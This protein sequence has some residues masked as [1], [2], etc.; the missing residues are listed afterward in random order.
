[1]KLKNTKKNSGFTLVELLVVIAIIAGLAAISSPIIIR[2]IA[3]SRA[4]QA[5]NNGKDIYIGLRDYAFSRGGKTPLAA[6]S[7][8]SLNV[9][10]TTGVLVDDKPFFVSG[11]PITDTPPNGDKVLDAGQ[12]IYS[13]FSDGAEAPNITNGSANNPVLATPI[14]GSG[15]G[16][17]DATFFSAAFGGQGVVIFADGAGVVFNLAG[18]AG[19]GTTATGAIIDSDGGALDAADGYNTENLSFNALA[20]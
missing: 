4:T 12:N 15:A 20:I 7:T 10:F 8:A 13:T 9:L 6:D 18:G 3:R 16:I 5:L 14:S 11:T 17:D 19:S 1:M 2:Q